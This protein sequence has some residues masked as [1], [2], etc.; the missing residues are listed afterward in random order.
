MSVCQS[1]VSYGMHNSR[2]GNRLQFQSVVHNAT[3]SI[4]L[5]LL[6]EFNSLDEWNL[7]GKAARVNII[8]RKQW[9]QQCNSLTRTIV[10]YLHDKLTIAAPYDCSLVVQQ[11]RVL[12][13]S[14]LSVHNCRN[15]ATWNR[16]KHFYY[17]FRSHE[18]RTHSFCH[19]SLRFTCFICL[20]I[21]CYNFIGCCYWLGLA[22]TPQI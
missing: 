7:P 4:M 22:T 14:L 17:I 10:A 9:G 1:L 20:H 2:L 11:K 18:F 15:Y 16:F 8:R 5:I 3:E 6:L 19:K 13:L 21:P 12:D